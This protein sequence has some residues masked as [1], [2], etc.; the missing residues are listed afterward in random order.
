MVTSPLSDDGSLRSSAGPL[1]RAWHLSP[2]ILDSVM[3]KEV[4]DAGQPITRTSVD[5]GE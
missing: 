3:F 1:I 2:G 5:D 4:R